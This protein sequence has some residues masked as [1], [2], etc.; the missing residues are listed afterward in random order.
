MYKLVDIAAAKSFKHYLQE[1]TNNM[2]NEVVHSGPK[3]ME[4]YLQLL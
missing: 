4:N 3:K 2:V 1:S